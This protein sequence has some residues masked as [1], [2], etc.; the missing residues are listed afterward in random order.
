MFKEF[1]FFR[2][3]NTQK[4]E[5]L[6]E[7]RRV[8]PFPLHLVKGPNSGLTPKGIETLEIRNTKQILKAGRATSPA[9]LVEVD[10]HARFL[11]DRSKATD[12][13]EETLP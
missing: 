3:R 2:K 6:N 1:G 11:Y 8:I 5:L 4:M 10:E 13:H 7:E 12:A 9:V